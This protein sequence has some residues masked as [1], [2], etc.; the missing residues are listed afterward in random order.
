MSNITLVTASTISTKRKRIR[1]LTKKCNRCNFIRHHSDIN[2]SNC[3]YCDQSLQILSSGNKLIDDFLKKTFA[4]PGVS[5]RFK[6]LEYVPYEQFTN[7]EYLA[8][9]GFSK[10]YKAIWKDGPIT[11][12]Y[13]KKQRFHRKKNCGVVLKSL[14][15][16]KNISTSFLN[17][18]KLYNQ[19]I[20]S[21][22]YE[23]EYLNKSFG[24]TRDPKTGN[25]MIIMEFIG[26]GDL[27]HFLKRNV[28]A[29]TWSKTLEILKSI[30]HGLMK[31]HKNQI[32]HC[33]FHSGNILIDTNN[34]TY[35]CDFGISR[36][37]NELFDTEEIYGVIPYVA[38]EV[39]KGGKF[40]MA[41]DIYSLGI[42]FW[43]MTTGCKPFHDREHNEH[44]ILDILKGLR[45]KIIDDTPQ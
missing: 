17:E 45:P 22:R 40:T 28:N 1:N 29:L 21:A 24:I 6:R 31:I 25:Y 11:S 27:H 42:I 20:K 38:P 41:S 7:I 34:E 37:A 12:W 44:L 32:I 39:L 13:S 8:E 15:D 14:N 23:E 4:E 36:P 19:C 26:N 3:I 16:S 9:G 5:N 35:I 18:L 10:I 33:D 30:V 43:E 2:S